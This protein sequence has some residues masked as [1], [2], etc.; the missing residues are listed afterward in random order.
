VPTYLTKPVGAADTRP[1]VPETVPKTSF[2]SDLHHSNATDTYDSISQ[3]YYNDKRY[4][5]ALRAFNHDA[6]LQGGRPVEVPPLYILKRKYPSQVGVIPAGGTAGPPAASPTGG[7]QWDAPP[8]PS[9]A[10]ARTT[11]AGRTFVVPQGGRTLE[12]IGQQTGTN[13]REI[14]EL[15]IQHLPGTVIPA[16]TELRMPATARLQ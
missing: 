9:P 11:G 1:S 10:P 6:P 14:Y 7:V 2:D 12:Q 16:G 5:P 4:A 15:N 8:R 13:W 3:E